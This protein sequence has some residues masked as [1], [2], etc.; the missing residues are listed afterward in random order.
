[1]LSEKARRRMNGA[2]IGLGL[3]LFL[4]RFAADSGKYKKLFHDT[5]AGPG[6]IAS[7][8]PRPGG[9]RVVPEPVR[10]T[11]RELRVASWNLEFL[12][13]PGAGHTPR[14]ERD[15]AALRRY[16]SRLGADI[17]AVQEVASPAALEQ[18]FPPSEYAYHLAQT[19]GAQRT[20]FVYRRDLTVFAEPDLD[21]L[22]LSDLR[23]GADIRV[24]VGGRRLRF[25]SVHMKAFC[26]TEPL[27]SPSDDCKK[28][29]AQ[30]PALESWV[31]ARA[32]EGVPFV[33]LGDFNRVLGEKNDPLFA[34]LDDQQPS[35]LALKRASLRTQTRCRGGKVQN[36]IDHVLLGGP[37]TGAMLDPGLVEVSY[38]AAELADGTQLSDHCPIAVTLDPRRM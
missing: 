27:D 2:W 23:G 12:D 6:P 17:V 3:V 11:A 24:M 7:V 29:K 14:S 10:G 19:G 1:M 32:A 31:D 25:L 38:D 33:V 36:V 18:V 5:V 21:A 22:A 8:A 28:L 34:E 35:S 15:Y 13:V 9:P 16:A 4:V 20:G 26:A 37:S 30:V